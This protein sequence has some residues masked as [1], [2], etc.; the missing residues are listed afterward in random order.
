MDGDHD[1]TSGSIAAA[2][3][4]PPIDPHRL[5]TSDSHGDP[6]SDVLRTVRL[7]G[8][9]F[10]VVDASTP[11]SIAVPHASAFVRLILPHAQH[12]VSYHVVTRGTGWIG[13]PGEAPT[14]FK[15]GD[16]LVIPHGDPYDM[17][18]APGQPSELD[19]AAILDF[20]RAMAAGELPFVVAEGGGGAEQAQFMC[21]FLGCDAKPFN[22]L[23]AALPRLMHI[24]RTPDVSGDLLDRLT[25][26]A[27]AEAAVQR[28][29]AE[30]IRVRLSELMFVEVVRRYLASL[31]PEQ[32]GWLAALR[33]ER[34]GRAIALLHQRPAVAWTL[35]TLAAE[36]GMSRSAFADRF[37]RVVG[38]PPMQ[39]LTR[40][41]VQLAARMLA[42]GATKVATVA[43]DVGYDSE[44]A[45]SRTFK[46]VSGISPSEWWRRGP[47]QDN[48]AA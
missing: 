33:D 22:P 7:N 44:A 13:V 42:D 21:G 20:F 2:S 39:Y 41:R 23:L 25:E 47:P 17:L 31:P 8:A 4:A 38:H 48:T 14:P 3:I 24:R 35:D 43:R 15:T 29:G 16:V 28:A 45:F 18:S 36:V 32:T 1:R 37:L 30:C 5:A 26:L 11:W 40:W 19:P 34:I 6:L 12:V 27:L 9:L 46:R 10:F